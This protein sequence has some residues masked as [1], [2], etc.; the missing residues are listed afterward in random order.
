[1][2]TRRR[3]MAAIAAAGIAVFLFTGCSEN[4][5]WL[6]DAIIGG[7]HSGDVTTNGADPR[8]ARQPVD[9]GLVSAN[10]RF[11]FDLYQTLATDAAGENLFISP[12][13]I[14]VALSMTYNG[15]DE[16]TRD[17]MAQVLR[18]SGMS[19]DELN[20][21]NQILLSNLV[22]GDERVTLELA[23]S[24]WGRIGVPFIDAFVNR[25]VQYYDAGME[26]V[27]MSDPA[28]VDLVNGWIS[29]KTHGRIPETLDE[30]SGSTVLLLINALY[31]KGAWTYSFDPD[32]TRD[33]TFTRADG[34]TVTVPM[35]QI[36]S[37]EEEDGDDKRLRYL[38]ND[39][40]QAVS[41]PYGEDGRFSMYLFLPTP[42][43][44]LD[45]FRQNLTEENWTTW[46][47]GF[48]LTEGTLELPRFSMEY[49]TELREVLTGMGM[50][51]AFN[52]VQADFGQMV[53]LS[54]NA[55]VWIDKV[56]HKTFLEVNEEGTEA[57]GV[58]VVVMVDSAAGNEFYMRVDR[59]FFL[60]IVDNQTGT[61]LFM[62]D[63]TDPS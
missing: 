26:L 28:T 15:A 56:I 46:M 38:R 20:R 30:L 44:S 29:D 2:N 13:S 8:L 42:S 16:A 37:T 62:G 27:N 57:A 59:P 41:L 22:Y 1:M 17:S 31:F 58:T 21:D 18:Y 63:V 39:D 47:D 53:N 6:F 23:N 32:D 25:N 45:A 54:Q 12:A 33:G 43:S 19:L 14:S 11:A 61:I 3:I 49:E 4:A 36:E 40:F 10:T 35:M 48:Q 52:S 34:G 51:I 5:R 55:N 24:L 50:G 60:S 9:A 7:D